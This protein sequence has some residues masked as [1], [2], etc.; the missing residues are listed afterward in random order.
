MV[1][2]FIKLLF[3]ESKVTR[4]VGNAAF[5]FV[6]RVAPLMSPGVHFLK[7]LTA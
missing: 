7:K 5:I 2:E 3:T 6:G 1:Y 4:L